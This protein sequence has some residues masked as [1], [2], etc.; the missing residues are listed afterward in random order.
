MNGMVLACEGNISFSCAPWFY[1]FLADIDSLIF[2]LQKEE[3]EAEEEKEEG[4][5]IGKGFSS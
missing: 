3:E 2:M 4:D 5:V 1:L